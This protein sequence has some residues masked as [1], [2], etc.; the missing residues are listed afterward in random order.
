LS[1]LRLLARKARFIQDELELHAS[2][3]IERDRRIAA[4]RRR[5]AVPSHA[6]RFIDPIT[7]G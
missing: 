5:T 1:V 4:S 2:H 3:T 6:M 7:D